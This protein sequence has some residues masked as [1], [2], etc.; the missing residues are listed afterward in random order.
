MENETIENNH[1]LTNPETEEK[2]THCLNCG[3]DYQGNYCP[4]CG[5]K[6]KTRRLSMHN[7]MDSIVSVFFSRDNKTVRTCW[8]LIVR[9]GIVARN[10][11]LGQRGRYNAPMPLLVLL[12]ALYSI[13]VHFMPEAA[14]P[15]SSIEIKYT[16]I[17]NETTT[18]ATE[19]Q[20]SL[21][22]TIAPDE[23]TEIIS[24]W[25]PKILEHFD[26]D[27][28]VLLAVQEIMGNIVYH[29]VLSSLL[30]ALPYYWVFRRRKL[31]RPDGQELPLNASEHFFA[32]FYLACICIMFAFLSLP[33]NFIPGF[34]Q[35]LNVILAILPT[36]IGFYMYRQL[37]NLSWTRSIWL[38]LLASF[39]TLVLIALC[40][41][42]LIEGTEYCQQLLA[43]DNKKISTNTDF[44]IDFSSLKEL[45]R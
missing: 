35:P 12:V 23:V 21:Q 26:L 28:V 43:D 15:Y 36:V 18:V 16:Y 41:F 25:D 44:H 38:N 20:D 22:V 29:V 19:G 24:I 11:I 3:T 2:T 10:F 39:L 17:A 14:A 13:V 27:T 40:L 31:L 6:A 37:L 30:C 32:L 7:I 42:L 33:L 45:F 8:E 9:P 1:T 4:E 34:T 5:Q